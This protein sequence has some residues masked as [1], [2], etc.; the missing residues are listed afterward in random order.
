VLKNDSGEELPM[1]TTAKEL[2]LKDGSPLAVD[3][4]I[5]IQIKTWDDKTLD[6]LAKPCDKL[7]DMK[8]QIAGGSGI[9]PA[10]QVLSKAGNIL[11]GDAN[12]VEELGIQANDVLVL[13]P[14]EFTVACS[15][16]DDRS[17]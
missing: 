9:S 1:G 7:S 16:P 6:L 15:M 11:E 10:N 13:E 3:I 5:P 8:K 12:A 2:G 4:K 14:R 17:W